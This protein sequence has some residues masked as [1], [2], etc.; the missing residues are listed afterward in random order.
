MLTVDFQWKINW[1]CAAID[2]KPPCMG[3]FQEIR[4]RTQPSLRNQATGTNVLPTR[5]R[6]WWTESRGKCN[7]KNYQGIVRVRYIAQYNGHFAIA[8]AANQLVLD[9]TSL[10]GKGMNHSVTANLAEESPGRPTGVI[11]EGGWSQTEP[12]EPE[13]DEEDE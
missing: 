3:T 13:G 4:A 11:P 12:P 10:F 7:G 6:V 8:A 9:V 2:G 1:S 5:H